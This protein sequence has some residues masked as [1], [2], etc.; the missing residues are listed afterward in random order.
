MMADYDRMMGFALAATAALAM[1][2]AG[3]AAIVL[4][5]QMVKRQARGR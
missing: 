4:L 5:L 3:V 1:L 2:S